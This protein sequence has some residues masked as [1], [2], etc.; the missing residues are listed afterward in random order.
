MVYAGILKPLIDFSYIHND[1]VTG[2][3]PAE[4][5]KKKKNFGGSIM[6]AEKTYFMG[7]NT[8]SG[9]VSLF[10]TL[11]AVNGERFVYILKGGPGTGKSSL[12]TKVAQ[13][14]KKEGFEVEKVTCTA[15]PSSLDAVI[16]PQ[17]NA[18][19]V[20]G[21]APHVMEPRFPGL[22]EEIINLGE[23]RRVGSLDKDA[24]QIRLLCRENSAM[25]KKAARFM[26]AAAG[27]DEDSRRTASACFD[28]NKALNFARRMSAREF[29]PAH[30][31]AG[32]LSKR[33]LSGITPDGLV[34]HYDTVALQCKRITALEDEYGVCA[35]L[36]I[37][38]LAHSA[39]CAGYDCTLCCCPL[40]PGKAEHLIIPELSFCVTTANSFHMPPFAPERC[41]H[42]S[43]FLD[44]A[45]LRAHR[46]R[47]A[48]NLKAQNDLLKEAVKILSA[49]KSVHD[50][51]EEYYKAVMDFEGVSLKC[52]QLT[53]ELLGRAK[54]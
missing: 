15:D 23:F 40:L 51:I 52:E 19:V 5:N 7:A 20:D 54:H 37:S 44:T 13:N 53:A 38:E 34:T 49:A 3:N 27:L 32:T 48:F 24:Q 8:Q 18:C 35:P 30:E 4:Y 50:M 25:H 1:I 9:F 21:T 10:D 22:D 36:I 14:V 31:K 26:S 16:F 45:A 43:R 33:F 42:A 46:N 17:L 2:T 6:S 47:L 39:V 12:M 11:Y 41:I 29:K 28:K